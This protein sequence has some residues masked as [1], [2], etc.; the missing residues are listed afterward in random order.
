[1]Q[2]NTFSPGGAK[3]PFKQEPLRNPGQSLDEKMDE[4]LNVK[5]MNWI[6][7]SMV[8][9]LMVFYQWWWWYS[10]P[11]APPV[12]FT[13]MVILV[14]GVAIYKVLG[15]R[16]QLRNLRLG[17]DG[18]RVVG[19]F[20]ETL[21]E[22]GYTVIHDVQGNG[23]NI[24]HV[25]IGPRG[26]YVIE[27]KARSKPQDRTATVVYD[28]RSVRVDG[29][30]ADSRPIDQAQAAARWISERIRVSSGKTIYVRPVV[31]YPGWWVEAL[32]EASKAGV[33]VLNHEMLA[34]CIERER[35]RLSGGDIKLVSDALATYVR[36]QMPRSSGPA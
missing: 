20:L 31:V 18:E 26:L 4:L 6:V 19:Q 22:R 36:S 30:P 15:I 25:L 21:R 32:P 9:I 14:A 11:K 2:N 3:R 13:G 35:T 28:G 29:G 27:T 1:M 17:R 7:S 16:K 24:D 23:F 33:W 12:F 10:P 8:L 5:A 34:K